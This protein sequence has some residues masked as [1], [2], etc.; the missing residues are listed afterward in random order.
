MKK[1]SPFPVNL[2]NKSLFIFLLS[3]L[4]YLFYFF[5]SYPGFYSL[6]VLDLLRRLLAD[7]KVNYLEFLLPRSLQLSFFYN[8][9]ILVFYLI[10]RNL[11][12]L[13]IFQIVLASSLNVYCWNSIVEFSKE[14]IAWAVI[15]LMIFSP[16]NGVMTA[17][18][19][20]SPL[21]AYLVFLNLILLYKFSKIRILKVSET[22]IFIINLLLISSLRLD[23]IIISFV[24]VFIYILKAKVRKLAKIGISVFFISILATNMLIMPWRDRVY[25]LLPF[26][27]H[28]QRVHQSSGLDFKDEDLKVLQPIA[29]NEFNRKLWLEGDYTMPG[30]REAF[31]V[32]LTQDQFR[33]FIKWNTL[34][35]SKNIFPLIKT[36]TEIFL[37]SSLL[38]GRF[39]GF[40]LHNN[41]G[42]RNHGYYLKIKEKVDISDRHYI[43]FPGKIQS[44]MTDSRRR[45]FLENLKF[46]FRALLLGAF[47]PFIF[48]LV[49]FVIALK[50]NKELLIPLLPLLFYC[51]FLFLFQPRPKC[52]YWYWLVYSYYFVVLVFGYEIFRVKKTINDGRK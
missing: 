31:N 47:I 22:V 18:Y 11:A 1:Y 3:I 30:L 40:Y 23:G 33:S 28:L 17:W 32:R 12:S 27:Y 49:C 44:L 25:L 36:Q 19:H 16:L 21:F 39:Q 51:I 48:I 24:S 34:F 2:F 6:D 42:Q 26:V 8:I 37:S 45:N 35:I 52:Y 15:L 9:Y 14:K 29:P 50:R 10:S 5:G 41:D 20:R 4:V 43:A 7:N 38:T 13:G 46:F